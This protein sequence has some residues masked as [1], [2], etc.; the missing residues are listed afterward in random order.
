MT[1]IVGMLS[2]KIL[3]RGRSVSLI[4]L[5]LLAISAA[6][7]LPQLRGVNKQVEFRGRDYVESATLSSDEVRSRWGPL[8]PTS[9]AIEGAEV[10]ISADHQADSGDPTVIFLR[11]TL[12]R[13]TAYSLSGGP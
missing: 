1:W 4:I 10:L 6:A 8:T 11:V 2:K 7:I 13:Y 3:A 5:L 12:G 9:V